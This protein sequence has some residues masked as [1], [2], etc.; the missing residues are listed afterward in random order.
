MLWSNLEFL[1]ALSANTSEDAAALVP[2]ANAQN[3]RFDMNDEQISEKGF[4]PTDFSNPEDIYIAIPKSEEIKMILRTD[5][6]HE[7]KMLCPSQDLT[8]ENQ[9]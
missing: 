5:S 8:T 7:N 3:W 2:R 1:N 6:Q 4:V 9:G